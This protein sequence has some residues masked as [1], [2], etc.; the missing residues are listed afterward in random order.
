M[1]SPHG[2]VC[3]HTCICMYVWYMICLSMYVY[4]YMHMHKDMMG[5]QR[6]YVQSY[7]MHVSSSSYETDDVCAVI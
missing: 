1:F 4:M 3:I 7:D 2:R 6:M 5:R